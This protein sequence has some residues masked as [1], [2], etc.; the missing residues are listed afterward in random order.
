MR[1]C[2]EMRKFGGVFIGGNG[3]IGCNYNKGKKKNV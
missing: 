1:W 2:A 3:Y